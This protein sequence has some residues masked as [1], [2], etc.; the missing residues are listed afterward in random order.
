MDPEIEEVREWIERVQE[1]LRAAQ[2][3]LGAAPPLVRDALFHCQQAVEKTLKAF[4]TAR[5]VPFAKTHDIDELGL[6]CEKLAPELKN[7]IDPARGFTVFAARFRYPG[8]STV[9]NRSEAAET[10]ETA[11]SVY[12]AI[13]SRL[14]G[15]DVR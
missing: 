5:K 9:P 15:P 6:A 8:A 10:L 4:L 2:V 14:P 12:D 13:A 3:D 7:I 11:R 1:D